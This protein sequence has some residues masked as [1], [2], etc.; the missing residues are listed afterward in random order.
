MYSRGVSCLYQDEFGANNST[1]DCQI[2]FTADSPP[3]RAGRDEL[4]VIRKQATGNRK[5]PKKRGKAE[6][7]YEGLSVFP[8]LEHSCTFHTLKHE[9]S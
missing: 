5:A 1:S 3:I 2:G 6:G 7:N 8:E 9:T 4:T